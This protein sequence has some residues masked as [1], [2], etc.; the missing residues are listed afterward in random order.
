MKS[1]DIVKIDLDPTKGGEKGKTRPCLVIVGDGHPWDIIIVVPITE[2][3][4]HRSKKFFV[5]IT[6]EME[7]EQTSPP[8]TAQ[9]QPSSEK[10]PPK[11]T[12]ENTT[13][14]SK[15]SCVDCFQIRCLSKD[16][17]KGKIGT[18]SDDVLKTVLSRIACILNIGEEHLS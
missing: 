3:K 13:G 11:P 1:G 6:I 10:N 5:P 4:S 15:P 7:D 2:D 18:V 8:T 9:H 12:Q 14:L 17:V 16:R